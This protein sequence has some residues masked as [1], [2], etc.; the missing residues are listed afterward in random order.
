MLFSKYW[1]E[2]LIITNIQSVKKKEELTSK[3][4]SALRVA[5]LRSSEE[6]EE[7][8]VEVKGFTRDKTNGVRLEK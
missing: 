7:L 2:L 8:R 6:L 1:S 5:K 3:L 4:F